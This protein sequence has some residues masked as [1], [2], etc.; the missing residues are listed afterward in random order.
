MASAIGRFEG[1]VRALVCG[2]CCELNTEA[3]ALLVELGEAMG[4]LSAA[5]SKEDARQCRALEIRGVRQRVA[6][7]IWRDYQQHINARMQYAD[8]DGDARLRNADEV[9][10]E[11]AEWQ[12]KAERVHNEWYNQRKRRPQEFGV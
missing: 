1:G 3:H 4:T 10:Q 11:A 8:P 2:G 7:Q 12:Q 6:V 5:E 9:E